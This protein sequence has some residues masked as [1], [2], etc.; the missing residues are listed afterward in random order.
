MELTDLMIAPAGKHRAPH[1]RL[2]RLLQ[3]ERSDIGVILLL[4]VMNGALLLATPLAVDALVNNI[5]FGGQE[6]VY[7]QAL[8]VLSIALFS[9]LVLLAIMRAAQHYVM[10]IIQRRLFVR[11]TA[12]LAYR[13]P[14]LEATAL[15]GTKAP[16]LVNPF[17][18]IVTVQKSSALLLLEGV[19]LA[20][21][22]LIGL[23]V[24]GFYHPFLLAF[25]LV[26]VAALAVIIVGM[27]RNAVATSIR[28][29]YAKHVVA[30]WLEQLALFPILFRSAGGSALACQRADALALEYLA[31]RRGH[32]RIL[33]RQIGGLLGSAHIYLLSSLTWTAHFGPC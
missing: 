15:E 6:G 33:L 2:F 4:A 21:A 23:I 30:G 16:E 32:F 18:E 7:L 28:E 20:L 10:E 31:A 9:F 5:A 26:L 17:F 3:A 19:N 12:D 24:L 14:H 25:D 29:S 1:R 13:L 27:G 22:T 8:L 11:I